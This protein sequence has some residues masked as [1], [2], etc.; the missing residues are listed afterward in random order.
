MS[1]TRTA[2]DAR[3]DLARRLLQPLA[4]N[5]KTISRYRGA[6]DQPLIV[7]EGVANVEWVLDEKFLRETVAT[8]P[9][10]VSRP[11]QGMGLIGYDP[12][13]DTYRTVWLDNRSGTFSELVGTADASGRV[14]VFKG[15]RTDQDTGNLV[16]TRNVITI[17][18]ND[19][20][21]VDMF[22][23]PAGESER[24]VLEVLYTREGPQPSRLSRG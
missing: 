8:Q 23:E 4:G 11:Y 3:A 7:T 15:Q 9:T 18:S 17:V 13:N 14:F 5:W 19:S 24:K 12:L 2:D 20:H 10:S 21:T 6:A 22:E 1:S 16:H